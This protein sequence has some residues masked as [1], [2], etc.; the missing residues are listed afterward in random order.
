[1]CEENII[2]DKIGVVFLA[3]PPLIKAATGEIVT[4]EVLGGAKTHTRYL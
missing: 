3:G 4:A 2:V 1:M